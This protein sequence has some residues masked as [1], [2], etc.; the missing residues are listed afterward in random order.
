MSIINLLIYSPHLRIGIMLTTK[1]TAMREMRVLQDGDWPD[2]ARIQAEAYPGIG[3]V[4]AE[5]LESSQRNMMDWHEQPFVAFHGLFEDNKLLGIM[6]LHDFQMN[7][8]STGTL[9][10]G[11]G[12]VAVALLH[13]KEKVAR[14][15]L[16]YFLRHYR[17]QG[18]CMTALYPFRPDFYKQMGFGFGG[19][20]NRYELAPKWLPNGRSKAH[21]TP[22]TPADI[23]ALHDCHQRYWQRTNGLFQR[24]LPEWENF[25][26]R[27]GWHCLGCQ[28][29]DQL[30]GYLIYSFQKRSPDNFLVNDLVIQEWVY[31]TPEAFLELSTF[32]HSQADQF[33]RLLY[34]TYD[35]TLHFILPDPRNRGGR[36]SL[37]LPPSHES[38]VQA[39]GIMYRVIDVPRLFEVLAEHNF[40][41]QTCR[42]KIT[43]H[44]S[45]LPENEG[46]TVVWFAEG[47][48]Y[49][50]TH[51]E[52]EVAIEM[53]IAE[54]SSLVT[55]AI[56]FEQLYHYGL[57]QISEKTAVPLITQLFRTNQKPICLSRF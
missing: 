22:L 47:K 14:D 45:F 44:D 36:D 50:S 25:L 29:G 32:L 19:K 11:I 4:T 28:Q 54:F 52:Y 38:N 57:A 42:L 2:A 55:G 17:Q 46:S 24:T 33:D 34:T 6:R 20:L 7:L 1:E 51:P 10:G 53:D 48:P 15:M 56:T 12:G 40:G 3:V 30:L 26:K 5:D 43:V 21:L 9:T 23:Q 41:G 8:L 39:V 16:L 31:E 27:P 18:A 49:V 13:K 35:D 37:L